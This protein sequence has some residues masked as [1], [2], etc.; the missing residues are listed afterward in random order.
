DKHGKNQQQQAAAAPKRVTSCTGISEGPVALTNGHDVYLSVDVPKGGTYVSAEVYGRAQNATS[1]TRCGPPAE[2]TIPGVGWP[3]HVRNIAGPESNAVGTSDDGSVRYTM[4]VSMPGNAG[5]IMARFVVN[6]SWNETYCV[7]QRTFEANANSNADSTFL[8]PAGKNIAVKQWCGR[9][10]QPNVP[11]PWWLCRRQGGSGTVQN[12]CTAT[13]LG[14]LDWT[15]TPY[16]EVD[17]AVGDTS[18]CGNRAGNLRRGCLIRY[19]Y[20]PTGGPIVDE[21]PCREK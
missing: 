17:G 6:Y 19:D 3:V 7:A 11:D 8:I 1:W 2:C 4:E 12:N 18:T 16:T 13:Y 21:H 15:T 20:S 9:E 14:G 5:S 10:L